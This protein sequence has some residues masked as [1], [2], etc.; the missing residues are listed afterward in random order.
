MSIKIINNIISS[1][2]KY[3]GFNNI[4]IVEAISDGIVI[5]KGLKNVANGEMVSFYVDNFEI[6]GLILN[7]EV[8]KVSAVIF[9]KDIQI[10]PGHYAMRKFVLMSVPVGQNLLG[11]VVN[12]LGFTLDEKGVINTKSRRFLETRAPSI[13]ARTSV[14]Y[15]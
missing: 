1:N 10:K 3:K 15:H 8:E 2:Y 14:N 4:G 6:I 5:I 11:R 7:L 12:P 13:I 9:E